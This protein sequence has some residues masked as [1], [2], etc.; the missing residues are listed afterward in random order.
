MSTSINFPISLA[1]QTSS[2]SH[3]V[4]P[5]EK[6]E[7]IRSALIEASGMVTQFPVSMAKHTLSI[8]NDY[9]GPDD[10]QEIEISKGLVESFAPKFFTQMKNLMPQ[11]PTFNKIF[12]EMESAL[13]KVVSSFP[14]M[15]SIEME[16]VG[17]EQQDVL[18]EIAKAWV[19]IVESY[20]KHFSVKEKEDFI[21]LIQSV[22]L[23]SYFSEM[24]K[25]AK[26]TVILKEDRPYLTGW[27]RAI[28]ASQKKFAELI[29]PIACEA[30]DSHGITFEIKKG[31]RVYGYLYGTMH[32]FD[33]YRGMQIV[34]QISVQ[35]LRRLFEC[36]II[37]TEVSLPDEPKSRSLEGT[38]LSFATQHG[39]ANLGLDESNYK[40]PLMG[41][42]WVREESNATDFESFIKAEK[43]KAAKEAAEEFDHMGELVRFV[44][45]GRDNKIT[46]LRVKA[47]A[48]YSGI[49]QFAW[50]ASLRGKAR[51]LMRS[52]V[53]S[54]RNLTMTENMDG[55]LKACDAVG[56]E[57]QE[58]PPK[59]FFAIGLNHLIPTKANP[60]SVVELL[61][62]K[63]WTV[64]M[65]P[66]KIDA[67]FPPSSHILTREEAGCIG[68][69]IHTAH[70]NPLFKY[71]TGLGDNS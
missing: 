16:L 58:S 3:Y 14:S 71:Q 12:E 4:P 2:L 48:L 56:L 19:S 20:S 13:N 51:S 60:E 22:P 17:P 46:L 65:P 5:S 7:R 27:V 57:N 42:C 25:Y 32:H 53:D 39:I 33:K 44:K 15:S 35:T 61:A 69:L 59:C 67:Q 28:V 21:T 24:Q 30:G 36:A 31:N 8:V 47:I 29:P 26:K 55:L 45:G 1:N 62:K 23:D 52:A 54:Q 70:G 6:L 34:T 68:E 37:G 63:G 9:L 40:Y 49:I 41:R 50:A 10:E 11:D 64:N 38:L 66:Q 18:L 43:E